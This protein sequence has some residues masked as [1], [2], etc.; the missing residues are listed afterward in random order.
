MFNNILLN[1]LRQELV[2]IAECYSYELLEGNLTAA[3]IPYASIE[4][5]DLIFFLWSNAYY[6]EVR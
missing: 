6:P 3:K 5:R 2:L 1:F 4:L